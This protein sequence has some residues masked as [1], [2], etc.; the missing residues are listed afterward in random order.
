MAS[1]SDYFERICIL[2][3]PYKPERRER[4]TRHLAEQ[5]F[6]KNVT[7][8]RSYSGD[9]MPPPAWW[10][11]GNGAWGCLLSHARV[12]AE[13]I[14]DGMENVLILE[15]DVVFQPDAGSLLKGFMKQVPDDWGQIYLGGQHL[16]D[17][18]PVAGSS[19][20]L[21][22]HCVNRTHA[23]AVHKRAMV[24]M[25][26]HI[27]HA[28]DYMQHPGGWHVDHQLGIAHE[29]GD[30]PVYGPSYWIAG[31]DAEWSNISGRYNSRH[32]WHPCTWS[33]HLPFIWL[34][35]AVGATLHGDERWLHGGYNLKPNTFED[36]GLDVA[37]ISDDR[38]SA[39]L[40][41]AA[42]EALDIEK[43]P[44]VQHPYIGIER[45]KKI[46]RGGV[47]PWAPRCMERTASVRL[48]DLRTR[49]L[50]LSGWEYDI[51]EPGGNPQAASPVLA[52][53]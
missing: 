29:R 33:K 5:G 53:D 43:L 47:I 28:P 46:W 9:K 8:V 44:A 38:L 4:L 2:N 39:W 17:P 30:W 24:R 42:R 20:V 15:D 36:I 14:A 23:F 18:T 10:N 1:L 13:A 12:L 32:W 16:K 49:V 48:H 41:V 11:A 21:K 19:Y 40:N 37:A 7:W 22:C 31:Q 45:L 27:W 26:Q 35:P 6:E 34:P 50:E 25:H 52:V 3:L 51:S